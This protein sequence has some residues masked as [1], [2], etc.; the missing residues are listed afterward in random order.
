MK[1]AVNGRFVV[2]RA[3][4]VQRVAR[5]LIEQL[6]VREDVVLYLPR[7]CP[8]PWADDGRVRTGLLRG[9]PWEQLELPVR[10]LLGPADVA[11]DPANTGPLRGGRRVLVL[12][13]VFP[14]TNPE[15]YTTSFRA[16]FRLVG[17]AA[18]RAERVVMFS[19]W[20]KRQ[21]VR[22]LG[23]RPA[24]VVV[25]TQG[26]SPFDHPPP[27][28]HVDATLTR[29]GLSP[30]Y[31]LTVGAGDGR[32]NLAFLDHVLRRLRERGIPD[33]RLVMVGTAYGHVQRSGHQPGPRLPIR[34]LGH[35]TDRDLHGLYAGAGAFCFP[36]LAEGF[37]R[38]PLEAMACGTPVIA[39]DYGCAREV[40]GHAAEILPLD[41]GAWVDAIAGLL[42]DR[43][44]RR[45]RIEAGRAHAAGYRWEDAA[46]QVLAACRAALGESPGAAPGAGR[47]GR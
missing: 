18:R 39:A 32:K 37:G 4:G 34:R 24:R 41:P 8:P 1:I 25:A 19:E 46:R 28:E 14:I 13:D 15:W 45:R 29:F 7:G 40:L 16:W 47:G 12:H 2:A 44:K 3:T 17:R 11:L 33:A 38:P 5:H 27:L 30:G 10:T 42:T 26:T 6:R 22:A 23:L 31:L 21:A 36:S 20:A 9:I 35:V 43:S